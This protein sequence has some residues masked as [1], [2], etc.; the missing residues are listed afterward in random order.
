M[1][2]C[3]GS[4]E[5][6]FARMHVVFGCRTFFSSAIQM[7]TALAISSYILPLNFPRVAIFQRR[8]KCTRNQRTFAHC[9][10]KNP[11][12]KP[13]FIHSYSP[14]FYY[15]TSRNSSLF[16]MYARFLFFSPSLPTVP[17]ELAKSCYFSPASCTPQPNG[18]GLVTRPFG[19]R[20]PPRS[21]NRPRLCCW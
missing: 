18:F 17:Y 5:C 9:I 20:F 11:L 8:K 3:S 12:Q 10:Q 13:L 14:K 2:F 1:Q 7:H 19:G 4:A 6:T 16:G 21:L 15:K